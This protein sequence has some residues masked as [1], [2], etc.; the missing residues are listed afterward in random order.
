MLF[1][2]RADFGRGPLAGRAAV[3]GA[4]GGG[5]PGQSGERGGDGG[6]VAGDLVR[7]ARRVQRRVLGLEAGLGVA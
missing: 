6:G 5:R 4:T 1:F 2:Q 7:R 3:C